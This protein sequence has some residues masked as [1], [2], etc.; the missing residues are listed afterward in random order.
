[1]NANGVSAT[2]TT[3]ANIGTGTP[4]P[5]VLD[6]AALYTTN[7]AGCHGALATSSKRGRAASATRNAISF[8]TGGMGSLSFLNDAELNAIATALG[9]AADLGG[10]TPPPPPPPQAPIATINGPYT[11]VV[12]TAVAF[13]ST[14]SRDPD[15]TIATYNWSFGDGTTSTAANPSHT[16]T[17]SGL[18]TVT[19]TLT[20]NSGMT[21]SATT[22]ANIGAGTPPPPDGAALYGSNCQSCHGAL[23][24]S[25]KRGR[26]ASATRNAINL[27]TGGMGS[28]AGLTDEQLNAIATALGGAAD[29]GGTPPPPTAPVA[30]AGGPYTGVVGTAVLFNGGGSTAPGSSISSY[31]WNFG[32]GTNGTG[33]NPSHTYAASGLYT[34]T[35]TVTA[36][37]GLTG[38]ATTTANIGTGTP[39]PP[40]GAALYGSNCQSCHGALATSSKRGRAASAIRNAIVNNAGGMGTTALRALTDAQLN[41]IATALGGA[42]DLGGTTPPP[43]PPPTDGASLYG[44]NCAGCHGA[45]ASSSKRGRAAS[46]IRNAIN[47]NAG[48]MGSLAGLTDAQ[49]NAI[50]TALG[51]NADLGGTTP[52]PTGSPGKQLYDAYCIACHG[53]GGTGGSGGRVTNESASSI[54]DAINN[55][56]D[57]RFLRGQLTSTQIQQ[58]ADYLSG[59]DGSMIQVGKLKYD[60]YCSACHG[61]EGRGGSGGGVRGES[62]SS[63]TEAINDERAMQSLRGVLS[64]TDIRYISDYLNGRSTPLVPAPTPAPPPTGT[65]GAT[66]Y[67]SSC[68]GCHGA[69]ATSSKRGRSAS[70]TRNAIN[71]NTGGMGTLSGLT[72]AQLNAIAT[73]LGGAADLGGTTPPPPTGT[74]GAALYGSNCQGCHGALASSS[75]R[76][77]SASATRNAITGN[78]GGMGSL[79]GLTNDQLNA[80]ATA[81]GGAADLTPGG[82]APPPTPI[83]TTGSGLYNMYCLSCHGTRGSGG[84]G[85]GVRGE[86]ASSITDAINN[87]R[88]MQYLRGT[89][90]SS[91]IRL[92][93]D[94]LRN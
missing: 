86:S 63:I 9:G 16:Y 10:T 60:T 12:G 13:N 48:G 68:Q 57:M 55:E 51:G 14:G 27:N 46:A 44:T 71:A 82:T 65:D 15:G 59:N 36:A 87:E 41:A 34:V 84:S 75:K 38:T 43:P 79:S 93:A 54:T 42:A 28:L 83:P 89:L 91:Q 35:L 32:D 50:A 47:V 94:Y 53:A 85:G 77:R 78:V 33:A 80:I 45:L 66:L 11:G 64:S 3:T 70:A 81:L 23:A 67:A 4:P 69:L 90:S 25:S 5:P 76:G 20:D 49:L 2:A 31:A 7:C 74:D 26:A 22:T 40:D 21:G 24:T 29:L 30:N 17:A 8:N 18:Y 88:A 73:A 1:M 58:I 39:P 62:A 19:L 72:D 37:N 61:A 92:I 56:G 6:G 52:P